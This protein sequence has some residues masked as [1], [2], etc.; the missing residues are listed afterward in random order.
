MQN[1]QALSFIVAIV[2]V[3]ARRF[4]FAEDIDCLL[5]AHSHSPRVSG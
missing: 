1:T 3:R 5:P 2:A 4:Y